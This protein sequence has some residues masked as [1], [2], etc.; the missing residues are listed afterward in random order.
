MGQVG[1]SGKPRRRT[2]LSPSLGFISR[3]NWCLRRADSGLPQSSEITPD[4]WE[5]AFCRLAV[6]YPEMRQRLISLLREAD[7]LNATS[8]D[9]W[10]NDLDW[11]ATDD[12]SAIGVV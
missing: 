7:D 4:K 11:L 12:V 2:R 6:Q 9:D 3:L 8:F 10:F 1:G 5:V